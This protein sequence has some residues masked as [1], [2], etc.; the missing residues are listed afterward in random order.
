[1]QVGDSLNQQYQDPDDVGKSS[2]A[3]NE[4]KG[5]IRYSVNHHEV[6][7]FS[8]VEIFNDTPITKEKLLSLRINWAVFDQ[9]R[10]IP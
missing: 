8:G 4:M 1:M 9:V 10:L 7:S 5:K 2:C 6:L 3:G